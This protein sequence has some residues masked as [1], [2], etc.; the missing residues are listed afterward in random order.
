MVKEKSNKIIQ[1]T[2]KEYHTQNHFNDYNYLSYQTST[3]ILSLQED[4]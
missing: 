3:M 4:F 1:H 2:V